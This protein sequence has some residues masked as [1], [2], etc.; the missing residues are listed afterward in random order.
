MK[1]D[2]IGHDFH[3]GDRPEPEWQRLRAKPP[4]SQGNGRDIQNRNQPKS[5]RLLMYMWPE[6]QSPKDQYMDQALRLGD[7]NAQMKQDPYVWMIR[8]KRD[9]GL[10]KRN[11]VG[12]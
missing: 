1:P 7:I 3:R 2:I 12:Q 6:P 5:L 8:D 9:C 11:V 4:D 10:R